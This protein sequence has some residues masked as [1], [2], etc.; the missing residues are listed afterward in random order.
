MVSGR[1]ACRLGGQA[2]G[3]QCLLRPEL[4]AIKV[5]YFADTDTLAIDL[6]NEVSTSTDEIADGVTD[7][8]GAQGRVIGIDIEHAAT[9]LDL[10]KLVLS[11]FPGG[12]RQLL[13]VN[14]G[15]CTSGP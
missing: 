15:I 1:C 4:Q 14:R 12:Y 8:C 2:D 9:R 3:S 5:N 13:P 11:G 6:A 7:D 10:G